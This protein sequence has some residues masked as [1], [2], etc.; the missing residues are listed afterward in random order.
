MSLR[1][2]EK[3]L[4]PKQKKINRVRTQRLS[5]TKNN[6]FYFKFSSNKE[7]HVQKN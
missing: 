3:H 7:K 5:K 1:R 2:T 6:N 4:Y